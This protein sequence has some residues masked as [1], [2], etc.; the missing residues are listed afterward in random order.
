M[1]SPSNELEV[2]PEALTAFAAGSK[3]RAARFR[4]L[5]RAFGD[6]HVPR[7][8]FGVMP[9]SFNL[10]A[11]YAEQFEACLQ[12]LADG[13]EMMADIAEGLTDT[14][15]AYT[16]TDAANTDLFVPGRPPA[17]DVIAP[18]PWSGGASAPNGS[19]PA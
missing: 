11:T 5:H 4:E 10:A 18:G 6:G 12:G 19:V 2:Q 15:A 9:A 1:S 16:G 17:P 3:D 14:A 13:A 8:A 7:H